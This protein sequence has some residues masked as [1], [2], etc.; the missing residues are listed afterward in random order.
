MISYSPL[1]RSAASSSLDGTGFSQASPLLPAQTLSARQRWLL[2]LAAS[3]LV[4]G[5][6]FIEAPLV[7]I[8][9]LLSVLVGIGMGWLGDRWRQQDRHPVWSDLLVGFSWTWVAG[10][11]Y[12]GWFRWEPYWHLPIEAIGL[13]F[14]LWA[15]ARHRHMIGHFF[16]LGS[17]LG[18]AITDLY[19]YQTTLI[20][21]WRHLMQVDEVMA[22]P[23]LRNALDHIQTSEGLIWAIALA[24]LLLLIGLIPLRSHRLHWWAF[25]GAV[26]STL[27][28]DGLFGLLAYLA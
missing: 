3:F 19:F 10:S 18:T 21:Y 26:I 22:R 4:S 1:S 11:L 5:P 2:W 6:V 16:Y 14:A 13:P 24:T 17:L 25:S 23:I 28:V 20:P 7:R 15:I 8:V 9:P 12:W 27:I